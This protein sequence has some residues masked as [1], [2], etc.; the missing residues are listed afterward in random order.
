MTPVKFRLQNFYDSTLC[1]ALDRI[2]REINVVDGHFHPDFNRYANIP[3]TDTPWLFIDHRRFDLDRRA[4]RDNP[5]CQLTGFLRSKPVLS[6]ADQTSRRKLDED[7]AVFHKS[8]RAFEISVEPLLLALRE[9]LII[10]KGFLKLKNKAQVNATVIDPIR[11]S[12]DWI[13]RRNG[14]VA[15]CEFFSNI[16]NEDPESTLTGVHLV[17]P[18]TPPHVA[19]TVAE[20]STARTSGNSKYEKYLPAVARIMNSDYPPKLRTACKQVLSEVLQSTNNLDS[21]AKRLHDVY[22]KSLQLP[23]SKVRKNILEH[24]KTRKNV[25]IP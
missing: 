20:T 6:E 14:N 16:E 3:S 15:V 5:D 9:G 13:V 10:A 23:H 1:Q 18:D 12:M 11:W 22:L 8:T 21:A 24:G 17:A 4:A 25:E 7:L 2:A 19:L